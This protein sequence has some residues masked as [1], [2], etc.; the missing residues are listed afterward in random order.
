MTDYLRAR[1]IT[2]KPVV[3]LGGEAV[4][5]IKDVV[6]D[7]ARGGIRAFTLSGRGLLAGPMKQA[8]SW[9]NVHA[10]GTG[11]GCDPGRDPFGASSLPVAHPARALHAPASPPR[12][13]PPPNVPRVRAGAARLSPS[14]HA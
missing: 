3:T 12:G 13:A 4:A 8:L 7:A 2:G 9:K 1:E 10:S 5:Q 6:F 11:R 14:A